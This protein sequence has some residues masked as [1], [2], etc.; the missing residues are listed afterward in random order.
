MAKEVKK[1]ER[2]PMAEKRMLQNEKKRLV[3]KAF[4][5]RVRTAVREFEKTLNEKKK[6]ECQTALNQV[7]S[8]M[9]KGVKRG[10]YKLGKARRVKSRFTAKASAL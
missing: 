10:I 6:E 9:D 5:S 1:K 8:L 7:F 3:N 4:K 2:R